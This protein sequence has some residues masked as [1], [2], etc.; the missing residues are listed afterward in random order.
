GIYVGHNWQKFTHSDSATEKVTV[1]PLNRLGYDVWAG[2]TLK[3]SDRKTLFNQSTNI[4]LGARFFR[5]QFLNRPDVILDTARTFINESAVI[6]NVG[7]AVQQY[8]KDKYIYRFGAN[9]D[10]PEG[11]MIQFI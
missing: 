2:K 10:V 6:G 5:G 4:I 8:Y 3:I 1:V 9:E 7:F 11:F